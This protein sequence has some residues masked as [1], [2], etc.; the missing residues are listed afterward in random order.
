MKVK[1]KFLTTK[2][3][4]NSEKAGKLTFPGFG[5]FLM[6]NQKQYFGTIAVTIGNYSTVKLHIQI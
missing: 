3:E 6:K 1:I 5:F 4:K 2:T